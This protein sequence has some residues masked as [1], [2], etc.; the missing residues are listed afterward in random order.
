M[1]F[2]KTMQGACGMHISVSVP[3]APFAVALLL[4]SKTNGYGEYIPVVFT[5]NVFEARETIQSFPYS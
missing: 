1:G 2:L 4:V 3:Q 5:Q